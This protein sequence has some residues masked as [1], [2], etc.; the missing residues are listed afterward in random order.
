MSNRE[1][2]RSGD[3]SIEETV[4]RYNEIATKYGSD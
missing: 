1:N 4:R 3:L 2:I